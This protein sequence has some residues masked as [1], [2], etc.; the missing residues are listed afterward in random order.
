MNRIER[1]T[2]PD[3]GTQEWTLFGISLEALVHQFFEI[4]PDEAG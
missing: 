3:G 1:T 4:D 2:G